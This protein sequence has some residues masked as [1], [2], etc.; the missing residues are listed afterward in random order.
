TKTRRTTMM[1]GMWGELRQ[2]VRGLARRPGFSLVAVLTLGVGIGAPTAMFGA[3]RAVLLRELPYPEA[4]RLVTLRRVDVRDGTLDEGISAANVRDLAREATTFEAV[5]VAEPWSMDL[6]REGRAQALRAWTV[7]E[8][9]LRALG[10]E[11]H[12]GRVFTAEEYL[13]DEPQVVVLSYGFWVREF[14]AD[15][16]VLGTPL[17]L[18]GAPRT[19]V[20]ILNPEHRFPSDA[21]LLLPRSWKPWD[22]GSRGSNYL[23]GVARLRPDV[24]LAR[25]QAEADRLAATLRERHP[26][27]NA[28]AGLRLTP[29]R[30][31]LFGSV[32][33]PLV[34][35]LAA[36]ALVL[37][38]AITNVAG[39]MVARGLARRREF[40]LRGALG[41]GRG[42]L[43][44]TVMAES[45][46]IAALGCG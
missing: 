19:V 38:V 24:T 34:V 10:D 8:G 27:T 29:L 37:L 41:A 18:E 11:P 45:A 30:E 32:R 2:A 42:R 20:G 3:V 16:T 14:G 35:L 40:A 17:V 43:F 23:T 6:L 22:E 5:G 7:S 36:A 26:D 46:V 15:S 44:R 12:L 39:L 1:D 28:H 4:D 13:A 33:S 9:F 21:P 31:H 25:A